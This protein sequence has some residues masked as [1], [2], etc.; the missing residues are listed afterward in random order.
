LAFDDPRVKQAYLNY[1]RRA[2][3]FFEPAY[4]AIGVE[5]NLIRTKAPW[6]WPGYLAL[7][8]FIYG[9][10]KREHPKMPIFDTVVATAILPGYAPEYDHAQ[11]MA[12]L[13]DLMPTCDVFALSLYPYMSAYKTDRIPADI[14]DRLDSMSHGR[15]IAIGESGYLARPLS[16]L[17]GRLTM[18]GT[19]AEQ[20]E[21]IRLLLAAAEARHYL[22]AV[23]YIIRDYEALWIKLGKTDLNAIWKN[24]GFYDAEGH[25][26]PALTLW[27]EALRRPYSEH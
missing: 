1:C 23:N 20:A 8:R 21:W 19:D 16:I 4:L 9:E 18:D 15:P 25:E 14:F 2:I 3:S 10:L 11:Q 17:N 26:R 22:F 6:K 27:R 5:S 13:D 24:T 12:V 7:H